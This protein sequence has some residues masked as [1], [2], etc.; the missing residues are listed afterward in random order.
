LI[1]FLVKNFGDEAFCPY[2]CMVDICGAKI[3]LKKIG[4]IAISNYLYVP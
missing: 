2:L 4:K 1:D 3:E